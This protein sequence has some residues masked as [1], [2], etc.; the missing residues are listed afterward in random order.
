MKG[1]AV[2]PVDKTDAEPNDS[3]EE[4]TCVPANGLSST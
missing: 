1:Q 4:R 3:E 2:K